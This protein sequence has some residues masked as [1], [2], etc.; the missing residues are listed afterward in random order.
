MI[1]IY[2]KSI[3]EKKSRILDRFR[4]GSWVDVCSPSE[5][6][7]ESLVNMLDLDMDLIKDSLDEFE[8]PRL[9][10]EKNIVYFFTR[11]PTGSGSEIRTSP[12][13]LSIGP[14]F[15]LTVSREKIDVISNFWQK[16]PELY[17]TQRAK[18][19]LEILIAVNKEYGKKLVEI[20]KSVRSLRVRLERINVKDIVRFVDLERILNDFLSAL[21]PT[22]TALEN[23]LSGK[24]IHFYDDDKEIIEDLSVSYEQQIELAKSVLKH[25]VN[26]RG[27]YS[28]LMNHDLNRV[29]KI[30]T[31]LTIILTIPTMIF[32]FYGM[33]VSLPF[34]DS[35]IAIL[36][37]AGSTI[38]ISVGL[39]LLFARN[40]WL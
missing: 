40:R 5:E 1:K 21:L 4:K 35:P 28:N 7:I 34:E 39:F 19:F 10:I 11:V 8:V 24:K 15:I 37:I 6:E 13:L 27:G 14:D 26:I 36:Y 9:E 29:I 38:L 17:T 12:M 2:Y 23:I 20:N 32:S 33:N 30:L 31:A 25:A 18:L 3:K 22:N 16:R